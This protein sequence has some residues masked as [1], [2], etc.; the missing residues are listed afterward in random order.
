LLSC[1]NATVFMNRRKT[2]PPR[3]VLKTAAVDPQ[4]S[5]HARYHASPD[6]EPYVEHYWSVQWDLRGLAPQRVETLP[7][8]SVHM[9]FERNVGGRI[10]GVARGKF[11]RL[12]EGEGG[13]FATK[14]RPGGFHPFAGVPVSTLTDRVM[15]LRDV[16]GAKGDAVERAVL[17]ERDDASRM[18]VVEDF[19]RECRPEP[20]D[21]VTRVADIVYAVAGDREILKVEDLVDRYAMNQRTLQRLFA[22][23]VGVSPKWVIQRY[24]LHEAAE[25]LASGAPISQSDLALDL[26]Y[27]D[28][29]H[30]AHDFKTVVG[31]SPAAYARAAARAS[32]S[33]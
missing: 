13:V 7:H 29:A 1:K 2:A 28:Q 5:Q 18:A 15:T 31:T 32:R 25:R 11:S 14:F 12:L 21:N 9:I 17:A 26:G 20:D 24:R 8:P 16:F 4:R 22:K 6:L 30:F 3:G 19:L 10:A 33:S 23:Y 27:T